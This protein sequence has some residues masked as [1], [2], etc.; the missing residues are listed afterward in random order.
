[1]YIPQNKSFESLAYQTPE[2]DEWQIYPRSIN[3]QDGITYFLCRDRSG[4]QKRLGISAQLDELESCQEAKS[5]V[6]LYP[7]TATNAAVLRSRL[8]WLQPQP[9]GL[10]KSF[11]FGDR[12]GLATPGHIQAVRPTQFAPIFAQQSVRENAR[13]RRTPQVVLDDATWGVFQEG[14]REPWG[15]D[16]DHIKE[17]IDIESFVIAGYTQFTFDPGDFV[18]NS[19]DLAASDDLIHKFRNLPWRELYSTPHT[20]YR[21]YLERSFHLENHRLSYDETILL[22]AAVKCGRSIAHVSRL[23]HYLQDCIQ[24]K[25]HDIEISVDETEMPT[26]IHEHFFFARELQRLGVR[27]TSLAPRFVGLFAKGVDYIGD[28]GD[29]A[30]DI[31]G[32]AAVARELG[33]YKISLHS[34]SDKFSIYPLAYQATQGLVHT[35]T[36]STSYLEALRV[37]AR[38]EPAFFRQVLAFSQEHFTKDRV[39]Y[40][41]SV[42]PEKVPPAGGVSDSHL[43]DL[44]DDFHARQLLHVT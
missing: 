10:V 13:T 19:A 21:D 18:D 39:T 17:T 11:S 22:R 38:S 32:H 4:S 27:W 9:L 31:N 34:G 16:A 43:P 29:F 42:D 26:S 5:G 33:P 23:Y 2:M 1:M 28:L 15:A 37:L 24:G 36:A 35:K 40:I 12:P 6:W 44:L 30:A 41:L 14:W 7:L 3:E 20:L 8:C 25:P